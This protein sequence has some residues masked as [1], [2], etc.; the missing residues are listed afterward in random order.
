MRERERVRERKILNHTIH[1]PVEGG[2]KVEEREREIRIARRKR[3]A[4]ERESQ[5]ES[6]C[7]CELK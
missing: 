2:G 4:R 3:T 6:V 1:N 7:V 5:R